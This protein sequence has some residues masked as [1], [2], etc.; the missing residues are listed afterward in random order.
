MATIERLREV[1]HYDQVPGIFTWLVNPGKKKL[2]GHVAGTVKS[3][4]Y[5]AIQFDGRSYL[6]HRL[7]WAWMTGRWPGR[8]DHRNGD[9]LDNRWENLREATSVQNSVNRR[10]PVHNMSGFKG[11]RKHGSRYQAKIRVAGNMINLGYFDDPAK[12]SAWYYAF[13]QLAYGEFARS[14]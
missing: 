13:A 5:K 3:T 2:N 1:L 8:I 14:N 11:V 7:A 4:G 12:A 9:C 10:R 6:A